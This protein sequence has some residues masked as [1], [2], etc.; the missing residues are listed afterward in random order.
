MHAGGGE[1]TSPN[2]KGG[3]R[4][5]STDG[6]KG[7]RKN[8]NGRRNG[9]KGRRKNSNGDRKNCHGDNSIFLRD[10]FSYPPPSAEMY[11]ADIG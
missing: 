10:S 1:I 5:Y 7:R 11:K 9:G 2:W 6:G 4:K 3:Y 8:S